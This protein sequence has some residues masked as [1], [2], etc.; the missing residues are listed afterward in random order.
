LLFAILQDQHAK[1][2]TQIEMTNKTN[3][4]TMM[5]QMNALVV[6]R[7]ARHA[8]QPD[9]VNTPPGSN[10]ILLGGGARAKK[11]R[12]KKVLCPNCKCL[13]MHKPANCFELETTRHCVTQDGSLSLPRQQPVTGTGDIRT[14]SRISSS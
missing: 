9:K 5:E 13:V 7:D 1:Q 6:A 12:R 3:M 10:V 8:H 4:D 11:P 14:R 2:I